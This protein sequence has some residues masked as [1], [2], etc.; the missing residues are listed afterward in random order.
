MCV[1]IGVNEVSS[2]LVNV[3]KIVPVTNNGHTVNGQFPHGSRFAA[4]NK[5]P[6]IAG[7]V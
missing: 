1:H 3:T 5:S 7:R 2:G 6:S 4:L